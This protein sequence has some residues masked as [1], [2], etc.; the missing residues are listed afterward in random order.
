MRQH[1]IFATF[2]APMDI[3]L[4]KKI[5]SN[6]N[7]NVGNFDDFIIELNN[8]KA[9]RNCHIYLTY[10]HQFPKLQISTKDANI[11]AYNIS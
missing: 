4:L 7:I 9:E 6:D 10:I 3:Y 8:G 1:R 5:P 11:S 2:Y